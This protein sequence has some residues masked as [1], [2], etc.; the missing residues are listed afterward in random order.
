MHPILV[1]LSGK[2]DQLKT[3]DQILN[4]LSDLEDVY[5]GLSEIEQETVSRLIEELNHRL[6]QLGT[7]G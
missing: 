4:A 5:D 1:E 7:E 2:F 6:K 3:R